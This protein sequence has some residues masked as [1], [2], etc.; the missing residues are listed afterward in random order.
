MSRLV[1]L[2]W[3][4]GS[5][6]MNRQSY[7]CIRP[8]GPRN[9]MSEDVATPRPACTTWY[10]FEQHQRSDG[11][12]PL[13]GVHRPGVDPTGILGS[14][15]D[16]FRGMPLVEGETVLLSQTANLYAS[17]RSIGGRIAITTKALLFDPD[18]LDRFLFAR[19][20]R[21][22]LTDIADVGIVGPDTVTWNPHHARKRVRV[23]IAGGRSLIF[24]VK[25][26]HL[27]V[28]SLGDLRL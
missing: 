7:G 28:Q 23:Q 13:T 18:Q 26:P 21:I 2:D 12:R 4:S 3:L 10:G 6:G 16:Y 20:Q 19:S 24:A 25:N 17:W 11:T 15:S 8:A 5:N 14:M 1:L 27:L 9:T 22:F